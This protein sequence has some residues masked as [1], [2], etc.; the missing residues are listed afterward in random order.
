[1]ERLKSFVTKTQTEEDKEDTKTMNQLDFLEK[2][3]TCH[4]NQALFE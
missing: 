3:L 2:G 4:Y 1:M